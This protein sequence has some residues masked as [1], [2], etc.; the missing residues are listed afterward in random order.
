MIGDHSNSSEMGKSS[1]IQNNTTIINNEPLDVVEIIMESSTEE[2]PAKDSKPATQDQNKGK[3]T[4]F[5][6]SYN[7]ADK[8]RKND[9]DRR[10]KYGSEIVFSNNRYTTPASFEFAPEKTHHI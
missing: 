6:V 4:E 3:T 1:P 7:D 2:N 8:M 10:I 9:Y 5:E